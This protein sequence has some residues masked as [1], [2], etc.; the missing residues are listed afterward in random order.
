VKLIA[1][2]ALP[3]IGIKLEDGSLIDFEYSYDDYT[4]TSL[5]IFPAGNTSPA[6]ATSVLV[7]SGC[8]E[9]ASADVEFHSLVHR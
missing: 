5:Y 7:D 9:W 3:I 4:Q 2:N 6:R 8:N 1:P